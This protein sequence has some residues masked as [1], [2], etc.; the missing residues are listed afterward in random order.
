MENAINIFS[1][2]E[3]TLSSWDEVCLVMV[4]YPFYMLLD[5]ICLYFLRIFLIFIFFSTTQQGDPIIH[6]CIYILF[7]HIIMLHHKRLDI[8]PRATQQDLIANL[9]QRQ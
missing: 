3:L 8:V 2:L 5:S 6:T 7:S 9:F 4:Y 1:Y